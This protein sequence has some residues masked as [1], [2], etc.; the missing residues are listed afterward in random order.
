MN[1][2]ESML[3][4]NV[5]FNDVTALVKDEKDNLICFL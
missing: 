5:N 4:Y 2:K 1:T 3:V